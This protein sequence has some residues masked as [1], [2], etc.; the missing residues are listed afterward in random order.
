METLKKSREKMSGRVNVLMSKIMC[1]PIKIGVRTYATYANC[2][3]LSLC[4]SVSWFYIVTIVV[5]AAFT[6]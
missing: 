3:T 5:L 6:H 4:I 1:M 2:S